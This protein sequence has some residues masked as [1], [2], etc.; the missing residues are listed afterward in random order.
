MSTKLYTKF[1]EELQLKGYLHAKC[2]ISFAQ[3]R[4]LI[5]RAGNKAL[6]LL[7]IK[8]PEKFKELCC[9]KCNAVMKWTQFQSPWGVVFMSSA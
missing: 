7:K 1:R 8:P 6:E 2:S 9:K 4:I 3:I 5:A